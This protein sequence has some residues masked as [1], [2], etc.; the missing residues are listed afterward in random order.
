M[1]ENYPCPKCGC[2][3]TK[4]IYYTLW[5]GVM[6]PAYFNH[7][8]CQ[9]CGTKYNCRT[10][11]S[12]DKNIVNYMLFGLIFAIT[13]TLLGSIISFVLYFLSQK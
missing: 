7:V 11:K 6:G 13:I 5:G 9:N 2:Y 4:K 3:D 12:N 8:E 1:S 10:G